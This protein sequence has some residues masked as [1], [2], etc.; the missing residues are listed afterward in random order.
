MPITTN[1]K[2]E[3]LIIDSP[4]TSINDIPEEV[5]DDNN[6]KNYDY[7]R[8]KAI[9]NRTSQTYET[10]NGKVTWKNNNMTYTKTILP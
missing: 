10:T 8:I 9:I 7:S 4:I 2:L 3:E 6:T 5:E 1:E